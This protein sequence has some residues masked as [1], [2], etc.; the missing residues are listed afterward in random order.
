MRFKFQDHPHLA[1]PLG[2]L[3]IQRWRQC[4]IKVDLVTSV[5]MSSKQL[6]VR[7]Y[8]QAELMA[9]VVAR[10]LGLPYKTLLMKRKE[11][12]EQSKLK[13]EERLTNVIGVFEPCGNEDLGGKAVLLVDDVLTTGATASECAKVLLSAGASAVYVLTLAR[14]TGDQRT[15]S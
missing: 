5:P 9:K 3:M 11:T 12:R 10:C 8:N 6:R 1:E 7:G 13:R 15:I 4:E 2:Q 14:G